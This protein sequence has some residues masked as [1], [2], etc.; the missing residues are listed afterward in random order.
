MRPPDAPSRRRSRAG[1][2]P[3]PRTPAAARATAAAAAPP[4]PGVAAAPSQSCPWRSVAAC[5]AAAGASRS[6]RA[7]PAV[8]T[9]CRSARWTASATPSA[10]AARA[11]CSCGA[12]GSQG[13]GGPIERACARRPRGSSFP[14]CAGGRHAVLRCRAPE[15]KRSARTHTVAHVATDVVN[16]V[17]TPRL[18]HHDSGRR[19]QPAKRPQLQGELTDESEIRRGRLHRAGI[20]CMQDERRPIDRPPS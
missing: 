15:E 2:P 19:R 5:A 7:C 12:C 13:A 10:A 16:V 18:L 14:S 9:S 17:R 11:P 6:G 8:R 3:R 20:K 4:A 1:R